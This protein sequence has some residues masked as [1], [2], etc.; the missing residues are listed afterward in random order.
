MGG[1]LGSPARPPAARCLS[2]TLIPP[3]RSAP[4]RV[5]HHGEGVGQVNRALTVW[6][7]NRRSAPRGAITSDARVADHSEE[8]PE[9]QNGRL[10]PVLSLPTDELTAS[11]SLCAWA[12]GRPVGRAPRA[13]TALTSPVPPVRRRGRVGHADRGPADEEGGGKQADGHLLHPGHRHRGRV[14]AATPEHDIP[15]LPRRPF[16]VGATVYTRPRQSANAEEPR[17][18]QVKGG[19]S[20]SRAAP[21]ALANLRCLGRCARVWRFSDPGPDAVPGRGVVRISGAPAGRLTSLVRVQG[22][23]RARATQGGFPA[24]W[25][26]REPGS[27]KV[28]AAQDVREITDLLGSG[29][30][31]RQVARIT[32]ISRTTLARHLGHARPV[33]SGNAGPGEAGGPHPGPLDPLDETVALFRLARTERERLKAAEAIR[34]A[35][36]LQMCAARG[37]V[38]LELLQ[39]LDGNIAAAARLVRSVG[40]F[41]TSSEPS[42]ATARLSGRGS[43]PSWRPRRSRCRS[44]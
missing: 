12:H 40:G 38:D 22:G 35:T 21:S 30:S 20:R 6:T 9:R 1:W 39:R 41:E 42:P 25:R 37:V 16:S 24:E 31:V 32:G 3:D 29:L 43:T 26:C 4:P 5:S 23:P 11:R 18:D 2:R 28:C 14:S 33:T 17:H 13:L 44:P 34:A 19:T 27:C 15:S 8:G 7:L 10:A 36:A